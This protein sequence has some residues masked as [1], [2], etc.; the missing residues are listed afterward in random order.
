MNVHRSNRVNEHR[1]EARHNVNVAGRYRA[2]SSG[3]RDV[4]IKEIS[5]YGCRFFDKFSILETGKP[6]LV[7]VG[8]I[9]PIPAEVKWR[10]GS[11]VGAEFETPLHPSVLAHIIK[12]MD[13]QERRPK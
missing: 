8:Q 11:V 3:A 10:K 13:D 12:H 9:G 4:W 6:I 7:R 2:R 5:E 1:R